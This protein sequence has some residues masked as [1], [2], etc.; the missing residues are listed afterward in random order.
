MDQVDASCPVCDVRSA[1][2]HSHY[3]RSLGD[4]PCLG[5]QLVLL[6]RIR[7]FRCVN[8]VCRRRTFA[9]RPNVIARPRAR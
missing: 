2:V 9:E 4:V 1:R 7:R 5:R 6:V 3:W 8:S